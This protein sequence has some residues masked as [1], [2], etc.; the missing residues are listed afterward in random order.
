DHPRPAFSDYCVAGSSMTPC[1]A[2]ELPSLLR[3]PTPTVSRGCGPRLPEQELESFVHP[4]GVSDHA[5]YHPT[6]AEA[7][8]EVPPGPRSA[9]PAHAR[10]AGSA[11][12]A[13]PAH[14]PDPAAGR[15]DR[16]D[17]CP[18][19]LSRSPPA[20]LRPRRAADVG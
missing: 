20:R 12:A 13:G 2:A 1:R 9:Y 4:N 6:S 8:A 19:P 3:A 11:R 16:A 5:A 7:Q 15:P 17:S 14:L 18:R 10:V